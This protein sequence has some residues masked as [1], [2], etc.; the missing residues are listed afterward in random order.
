MRT[1]LVLA[2]S[3][4][5]AEAGSQQLWYAEPATKWTEAL[6]LGNGRMGAMVY[7]GVQEETI[8]LNEQ[9]LYAG[10]PVPCG[11]PPIHR[12]VTEACDLVRA[13][14]Y[15]E[16][17][18]LVCR[19]MTGRLHQS[20]CVLGHLRLK[21]P[22][23]GQATDYRRSLD[24]EN[25]VAAVTYRVGNRCYRREMFTSAADDVLVIHLTCDV[26]GSISFS[27]A[28][29]TPH[30][31][32]RLAA[33]DDH[34]VA[35]S[36]KAPL[37][38]TKRDIRTIQKLGDQRKYPELFDR[39][40]K[41]RTDIVRANDRVFYAA[42]VTGPGMTFEAALRAVAQSGKVR[43][44]ERGLHVENADTV[45]LLLV[46]KTS[47]NG[48]R[49]SPSREGV[50]P[51]ALSR[52]SLDATRK[53]YEQ[54]RAAHVA[55]YRSLFDR[56]KI[57]LGASKHDETPTNRRLAAYAAG[58]DPALEAV[59]FQY[60]RYLL[61]SSSRPG[62]WPAN[63]Q[64]LWSEDVV[65]PWCGAF[66]LDINLAMNYWPAEAANLGECAEPLVDYIERL[67]ANGQITAQQS[68]HCRG[69]VAHIATCIWCNTDP[70]DSTPMSVWNMGGVWLCRLLWDHYAFSGDRK[71]LAARAYPLLK[72][73]S[74]FC[75]DWLREDERG[76]LVTPVSLSPENRFRT[77]DGQTAAVS[78]AS[79]MDMAIIREL[80]A[81]TIHAAKMLGCDADLRRTL[82]SALER[83]YP[84]Q[85][86]RHGQLQEWFKDWD[87]PDDDHRHLSHLWPVFPGSQISPAR[88]PELAA[89][90]AKS[91]EMRGEGDLE[92]SRAWRIGLWSRLGRADR[93]YQNVAAMVR[94]NM[95]PNLTSRCYPKQDQPF[96]I[97]GNLGFTAGIAAMLLQ[98][99]LDLNNGVEVA[100]LHLLPALP[101]AWPEGAVRG[102]R[103]SGGAVVGLQWRAGRLAEAVMHAQVDGV[104]RVRSEVPLKISTGGKN[105]E[106]RRIGPAVIEWNAQRGREY[107]LIPEAQK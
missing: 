55:D 10:E 14:R 44:D 11:Q 66:H 48:Y 38:A 97:D 9:T 22:H 98:S 95:N 29:D 34:T 65:T 18:E 82:Q 1:V 32:A 105:V 104:R 37:Y 30:R 21:F 46:A 75:L 92:F 100:E 42:T 8:A 45:T 59:L 89:A 63:L 12:H 26:R 52:K 53:S 80:F 83:L 31:F 16:A 28:L 103:A 90:A 27:A 51:S 13:G 40:G 73:A 85:V 106:T 2:C 91:L 60:G 101:A 71:F 36:A 33:R 67:A 70:L 84:Y 81:N 72:G 74:L 107:V 68:Y 54:L 56:A 69:W 62:G 3:A 61:I 35:L 87:R 78:I 77:A 57:D 50:D 20:Y 4:V 39:N 94:H 17:D 25:A 19:K 43:A 96:E 99:R 93:A 79:T 58:R 102:L 6:P 7:G 49:R 15:T 86:G 24:L 88:T 5:V 41:L 23:D 47:F 76:R 64:G